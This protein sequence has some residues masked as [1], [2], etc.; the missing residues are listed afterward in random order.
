MEITKKMKT[1]VR[2]PLI[3]KI[4]WELIRTKTMSQIYFLYLSLIYQTFQNPV[5]HSST[6][7]DSCKKYYYKRNSITVAYDMVY[8][9]NWKIWSSIL[10][11]EC[12]LAAFTPDTLIFIVF[13]E[14]ILSNIFSGFPQV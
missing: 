12:N 4:I 5:L 9:E 2:K 3:I 13:N 11:V 7:N 6:E 14:N 10:N 1:I 8:Y